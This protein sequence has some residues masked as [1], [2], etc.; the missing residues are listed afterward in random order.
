MGYSFGGVSAQLIAAATPTAGGCGGADD[1]WAVGARSHMVDGPTMPR[2]RVV[3]NCHYSSPTSHEQC[4]HWHTLP[5][6]F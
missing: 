5:H 2:S 1:P 6:C 3:S 4:R